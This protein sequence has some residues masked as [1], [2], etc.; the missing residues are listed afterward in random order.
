MGEAGIKV[1]V[2][3]YV[4]AGTEKLYVLKIVA[5]RKSISA[6]RKIELQSIT[7]TTASKSGCLMFILMKLSQQ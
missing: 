4:T 6:F 7:S 3:E 1:N 5:V 2:G